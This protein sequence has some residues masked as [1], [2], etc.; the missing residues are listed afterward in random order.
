MYDSQN[1]IVN[2]ICSGFN[3]LVFGI[4][5]SSVSLYSMN[6]ILTHEDKKSCQLNDKNDCITKGILLTDDANVYNNSNLSAYNKYRNEIST[7][8]KVNSMA[9]KLKTMKWKSGF[10]L[11]VMIFIII[12]FYYT[13]A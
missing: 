4:F 8:N 12:L 7:S 13:N 3:G 6:Y 11:C 2:Y 5:V 9:G 1:T 10:T